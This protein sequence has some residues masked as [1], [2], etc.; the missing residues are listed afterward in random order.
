MN[1][2]GTI[3][4]SCVEILVLK[5]NYPLKV[6]AWAIQLGCVVSEVRFSQG[7][8]KANGIHLSPPL[9]LA[10]GIARRCSPGFS[11]S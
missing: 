10:P 11:S 5:P 9:S 6:L 1:D 4:G 8:R 2:R 7:A 3:W